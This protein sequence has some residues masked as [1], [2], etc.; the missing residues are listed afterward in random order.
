MIK[1]TQITKE[2]RIRIQSKTRYSIEVNDNGDKIY[3]DLRDTSLHSK[4]VKMIDTVNE[5]AARLEEKEAEIKVRPDK[6]CVQL[7]DPGQ[8]AGS[9]KTI[10]TQNQYDMMELVNQ[11][12]IEQRSAL[13]AF[14]GE[15]ACQK[16]FGNDNYHGMLDDLLEA[17]QPH[18]D[19]MG[20]STKSIMEVTAQKY[21]PNRA[22]RRA[23]AKK[24]K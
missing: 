20:V 5:L 15:G 23:M 9:T 7:R 11:F 18:F 21:M 3:F 16:I 17:L 4:A 10:M 13:D 19:K 1:V 12:Y 22:D 6:P 2:N 24:N 8:E 14:M